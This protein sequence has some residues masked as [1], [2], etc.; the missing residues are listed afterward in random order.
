MLSKLIEANK[1]LNNLSPRALIEYVEESIMPSNIKEMK[2]NG[3]YIKKVDKWEL[4]LN[5][6][7][8]GKRIVTC[9]NSEIPKWKGNALQI[10]KR[11][12]S[13]FD[14]TSDHHH[15]TALEINETKTVRIDETGMLMQTFL[16]MSCL[17]KACDLKVFS[18]FE[19]V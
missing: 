18:R 7:D 11:I 9:I 13:I 1:E 5:S 12:S 8:T 15:V 14:Y 4:F 3:K 19:K 16:A 17:A 2:I 10:A 6:T